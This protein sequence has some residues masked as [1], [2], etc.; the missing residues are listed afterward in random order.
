MSG[1]EERKHAL[2]S[3][4]GA[5]RWL[6]CPP[7]ALLGQQ[8][9]DE[10]SEAA[11]EGT[12]AHELCE[13]KLKNY[14]FTTD[15]GK[16]KLNKD[17]KVLKEKELW[18]NEMMEHSDTYLE[19][20]KSAALSFDSQPYAAVEKRVDF[21]KYVPDGF[22]TADCILLSGDTIWVID[23]KY[24]KSPDGRVSAEEN[25]QMMLYALG[26][27]EVYKMLYPIKRIK[28]SIVQPRLPDGISEWECTLKHLLEFGEYIKERATLAIS[29][30][31][32]FNPSHKTC[33]YCKA[34]AKCRARAEKNVELAFFADKKPP[35]ITNDEVG[36][37]LLKGGDISR[38]MQ[39]LINYALKEC[40]AG[41]QISGWKAVEGKSSRT[42][43]DEEAAFKVLIDNGIPETILYKNVPLTLAQIEKEIGQKQFDEYVG[44][45]VIKPPGKPTLVQEHDKRPAITYKISADEA[46]KEKA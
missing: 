36:D 9:P 45:F 42:W 6:A 34:R 33:K 16:R 24:G 15:Y 19:Y 43:T 25:P 30:Q 39:D 3:A 20:V 32:E 21:A 37:Y 41:R 26:A 38:W 14:F 18:Q 31:G 40:L 44:Q 29:G 17:I 27:Y 23:F 13:I 1:H 4:S 7:S 46:F 22:G 11:R 28:L 12:L 35:L 2:L 5:Y 8:F 10:E